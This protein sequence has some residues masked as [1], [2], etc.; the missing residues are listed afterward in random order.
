MYKTKN[1]QVK[2]KNFFLTPV[3][4]EQPSLSTNNGDGIYGHLLDISLGQSFWI[5]G[6]S[7][8]YTILAPWDWVYAFNYRH[9]NCSGQEG[10]G[11]P[12]TNPYLFTF[13][14]DPQVRTTVI[15][16]DR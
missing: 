16:Y 7:N 12:H 5:T 11:A 14:S 8:R 1:N 6:T 3:Y 4:M 15:V 2:T 9:D 10:H 13:M